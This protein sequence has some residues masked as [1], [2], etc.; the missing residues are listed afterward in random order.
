[1]D[2]IAPVAPRHAFHARSNLGTETGCG[3]DCDLV[4]PL[5][6]FIFSVWDLHRIDIHSIKRVVFFFF[7]TYP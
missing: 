3:F 6:M 5:S 4:V 7:F 2:V 1:L